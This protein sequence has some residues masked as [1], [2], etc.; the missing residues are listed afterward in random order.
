MFFVFGSG[1][2]FLQ[3]KQSIN[4][5]VLII[6]GSEAGIQAALDLADAGVDV[7]MVE[8]SPFLG[9][10]HHSKLPAHLY[11]TRMLE[12]TRHP[13]IT[14]WTNTVLGEID[15]MAG[16]YRAR[17]RQNPRY[18]DPAK[19]TACGDCIEACPV[20]VPGKDRKAIYIKDKSE[21]GCVAID[22][23]GKAPCTDACPGGIHVQGYVALVAEGRFQEAIDLIRESIPFPGIC[24][25]ICT[26]PC[27]ITCRRNEVDSPVSI[28]LLKRFVSDW[29]RRQPGKPPEP[30]LKKTKNKKGAKK[31]AV[32]GAGP[33]GMTA[34]GFLAGRGYPV[35]VY[36]KLPVIGGMLAVGIP[37]F[38]LPRDVI[39]REYE[40]IRKQGVDIRLNTSIGPQG[41]YSI[42]DLFSKGYEA[43]CLTVG[44]HKSL[45]LGIPGEKLKGV[46]QGIDLLK[47]VSLSQQTN[48][49]AWLKSLE[50]LLPHGPKTRAAVLGGGNTAM[51]VSRTLRRLGLSEVK[52]LYRRTRDE[53][54]ALEEEIDEAENEGV[55]IQLLTAPK[56]ISG[57]IK[58]C[59]TGLECLRIEL[60]APDRSGRRRPI[61]VQGS[62]YHIDLDLVVLAIGQEPDLGFMS[63]DTGIVI[64]KDW[65]IQVNAESF[66]TSRSGVFA[67][68]DAVTRDGMSAIEAI[69]MGKKMAREVDLFLK[70]EKNR[71]APEKLFRPPVSDREMA[72]EELTP[73]P[74]IQVPVLPLKKRMQG[75]DEVEIGY[76]EE[77][78]VKEAERCLKCGPCSECM[79]CVHVCKADALNHNQTV[80]IVNLDM[81]TVIYADDPEIAFQYLS[82]PPG[83]IISIPPD[84]PVMGSAAAAGV[85]TNRMFE[86]IAQR[87]QALFPESIPDVRIGVYI[88]RCGDDMGGVIRTETLQKRILGHADVVHT[89]ILP[90]ACRTDAA[91]KI[92]QAISDHRLNRVVLAACSCCSSDQIC[93]SCTFQRVRCKENLGIYQPVQGIRNSPGQGL[94]LPVNF[95]FVN[96]REQCAWVHR[97][98]PGAATEKAHVLI[99]GAVSQIRQSAIE[100][101]E[102][103]IRS[104]SVM[105]LGKGRAAKICLDTLNHSGVNTVHLLEILSSIDHSNG[106]YTTNRNGHTV[107]SLSIIVTP[108]NEFE[109]DQIM[110][111]LNS[112]DS[113]PDVMYRTGQMETTRPGVFFCNPDLEPIL[114][115]RAVAVRCRGWMGRIR[116]YPKRISGKVDPNRCR[117]CYTCIDI[118]ET[119]APQT[120]GRDFDRH[121]WID[122][123]VCTGCGA[124]AA[125]CPSNAIRAGDSTDMQ[126]EIM[127]ED[128]L[129]PGRTGSGE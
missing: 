116:D 57:N 5:G 79:A 75:F 65:R 51:D 20:T 114:T 89:D 14:L 64:G 97:D 100:P 73:V 123:A 99:S 29:E 121:I 28:R 70:G 30:D 17:L 50:T 96:I 128:M 21:P 88:C 66:M 71:N 7:H 62:E 69:G 85:K 35:T 23:F 124:C 110:D 103:L 42:E 33:A 2:A 11:H 1:G 24:G 112:D 13:G 32:I 53:M 95:E 87:P 37:A 120:M 48:D 43:V 41:D 74:K 6:G 111:R 34:A 59:V 126:L 106:Y 92:K 81:D 54:P 31:V 67:A 101:L 58:G 104:R 22:K 45:S 47:T 8:P 25:R 109:A 80:R 94:S 16:N 38:R 56:S 90:Y 27:E 12:A 10:K 83:D 77:D 113:R 46:V 15:G 60:G 44:A 108:K 63:N 129:S 52:I 119:G 26:H 78:A 72:P 61:P 127:I 107:K 84:D 76:S 55:L 98:N 49:P 4:Q 91:T 86:T 36:D 122:P 18:V 82:K 68:G 93:F 105:I 115:G 118:C 39:A 3:E 19:C 117:M 40:T 125:S 9:K 102:P